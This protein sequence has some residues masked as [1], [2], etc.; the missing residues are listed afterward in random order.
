MSGP[1][2][3]RQEPET[4]SQVPTPPL[5]ELV[6]STQIEQL[7]DGTWVWRVLDSTGATH[8]FGR[9]GNGLFAY[10]RGRHAAKRRTRFDAEIAALRMLRVKSE[11]G[12]RLNK[13]T[14]ITCQGRQMSDTEEDI[15]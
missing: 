11:T 10:W 5:K 12:G 14:E 1:W 9:T 13:W 2:R 8:G 15:G 7:R 6:Y 3:K 4:P